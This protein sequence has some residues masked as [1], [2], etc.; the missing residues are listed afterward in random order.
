[1]ALAKDCEFCM[2]C[3]SLK[4]ERQKVAIDR[5][6]IYM[7]KQKG[8]IYSMK[9]ILHGILLQYFSPRPLR[10]IQSLK[11]DLL[12]EMLEGEANI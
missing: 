10:G 4:P 12:N 5:R 2:I 6:V 3:I 1:M 9:N 8:S 11:P 7:S